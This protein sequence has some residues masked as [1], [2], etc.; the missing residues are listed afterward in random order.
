MKEDKRAESRG[1]S[2]NVKREVDH[3]V[4]DVKKNTSKAD[5][6]KKEEE[7]KKA[8]DKKTKEKW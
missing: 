3:L 7:L 2:A 1:C 4:D 8:F 6:K 5:H